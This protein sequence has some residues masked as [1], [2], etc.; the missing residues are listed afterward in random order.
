V[1]RFEVLAELRQAVEKKRASVVGEVERF[2]PD[3][4]TQA[5]ERPE[6]RL[7]R[8]AIAEAARRRVDGVE[9]HADR[10]RLTVS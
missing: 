4:E 7:D 3:L 5:R 8:A 6:H 2:V 9:R 10:H 1:S